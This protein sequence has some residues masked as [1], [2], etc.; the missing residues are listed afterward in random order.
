MKDEAIIC[1]LCRLIYTCNLLSIRNKNKVC[2]L[3]MF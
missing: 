2:K 1:L 3:S